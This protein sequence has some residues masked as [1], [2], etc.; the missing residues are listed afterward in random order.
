MDL[1]LAAQRVAAMNITPGMSVDLRDEFGKWCEAT[2][3]HIHNNRAFVHYVNWDATWDHWVDLQKE[4]LRLA[5]LYQYTRSENLPKTPKQETIQWPRKLI[6][7]KVITIFSRPDFPY[8]G[9]WC[10]ASITGYDRNQIQLSSQFENQKGE[11]EA[12]QKLNWWVHVHADEV[13]PHDLVVPYKNICAVY[14][15]KNA[16]A[17]A[18]AASAT[19]GASEQRQTTQQQQH[20][21]QQPKTNEPSAPPLSEFTS[22]AKSKPPSSSSSSSSS[23]SSA[24]SAPCAVCLTSPASYAVSPC[25]HLCYCDACQQADKSTTCPMCRGPMQSK[26]RIFC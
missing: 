1:K 20:Q 7:S 10:F 21:Q 25:G 14:T 9:Q 11:K 8:C 3:L 17:T 23:E 18:N 26:L 6:G 2:I 16:N 12:Y 4:V 5:P 15:H 24:G 13:F 22:E 19:V